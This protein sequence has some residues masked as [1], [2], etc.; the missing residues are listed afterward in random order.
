M[1]KD[2]EELLLYDAANNMLVD[3]EGE[4]VRENITIRSLKQVRSFK[5]LSDKDID[6]LTK[7]QLSGIVR[8]YYKFQGIRIPMKMPINQG[9]RDLFR[10][11]KGNVS[12]INKGKI[13]MMYLEMSSRQ[14]LLLS[15]KRHC[16]SWTDLR[17]VKFLN[18]NSQS[19]NYK[20]VAILKKYDIMREGEQKLILNPKFG[21]N[22]LVLFAETYN[23]F[24]DQLQLPYLAVK[25]FEKGFDSVIKNNK[26]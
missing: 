23:A 22:S 7:D 10:E 14:G 3:F 1:S 24:K 12:E 17:K 19:T 18:M 6:K 15:P 25:Y 11:M 13:S 20:F 16:K 8:F 9:L 2:A 5:D 21:Y 4:I 26:K